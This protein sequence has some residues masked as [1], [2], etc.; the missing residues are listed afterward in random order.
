VRLVLI[1]ECKLAS[2]DVVEFFLQGGHL[3][4]FLNLSDSADP[5]PSEH[6]WYRKLSPQNYL[7]HF[8]RMQVPVAA[9]SEAK[10]LIAWTL[11]S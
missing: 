6:S 8:N 11:I 4:L 2:K 10:A 5:L 3:E 9:R 1:P 7:I